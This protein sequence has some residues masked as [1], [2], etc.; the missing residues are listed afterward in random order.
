M[1]SLSGIQTDFQYEMLRAFGSTAICVDATHNTTHYAG[2]LLITVLTV[3]DH[4][5]GYPC[6]WFI[7]NSEARAVLDICFKALRERYV[8][9][10]VHI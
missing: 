10:Y 2:Y 7:V 5:K 1:I 4:G 3:G 9:A 6:A 8:T